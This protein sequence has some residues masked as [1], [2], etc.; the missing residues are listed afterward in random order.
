MTDK[1]SF[2]IINPADVAAYLQSTGWQKYADKPGYGSNWQKDFQGETAELLL[3]VDRSIG[4]YLQR[5]VDAV[6]L[7]ATV[8]QRSVSEALLDLQLTSTDVLRVRFSYADAANGTIPLAQ[9]ERLIESTKE[10]FLA[11]GSAVHSRR[12]YFATNRPE[13]VRQ[14]VQSLRLGQSEHGSYVLTVL[15]RVSPEL[16]SDN[17]FGELELPFERKALVG[18]NQA[19]IALH[20]AVDRAS[21]NF[22]AKVFQ[23]EIQQGVS[24]NLCNALVGMHSENAQP[25]DQLRFGFT[26]ARTRP[27]DTP[28]PR[29]V[30]FRAETFSI[31]KEAARVLKA[32]DPMDDQEIQGYVVKLQ[33]RE[34]G[35]IATVTT[36]IEGQ[37]RKVTIELPEDDH[38]RA[39][40][41]YD[42]RQ[43]ISCRGRLTK[44][45]QLWSLKEP[46]RIHFLADSET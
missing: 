31:I 7:I 19:L 25:N 35:G 43:E 39:I 3:P 18:L 6:R 13:E 9:A 23:D 17:L 33:Q 11:A 2:E 30:T 22:T 44:S 37:P 21:T 32:T 36:V 1:Q 40:E 27:I 14:F 28:I 42:N 46:G 16:K 4:D 10:L 29:D 12:A 34:P 41:A 8:E 20:E 45:G 24:A 26:W 5:M 38:K 15:S